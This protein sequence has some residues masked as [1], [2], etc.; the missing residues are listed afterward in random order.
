MSLILKQSEVYATFDSMVD[1]GEIL[2]GP[3]NVTRIVDH[4]FP[5]FMYLSFLHP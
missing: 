1:K 2:Y 3:S 5:V 4:G